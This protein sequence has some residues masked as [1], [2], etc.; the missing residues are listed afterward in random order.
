MRRIVIVAGEASGD[1]HGAR[2]ARELQ[3]LEPNLEIVGVGGY[4]MKQAGVELLYDSSKWGVVG[5]V[6]A[7]KLIPRLWI[8][9]KRLERYLL[10]TKPD[11]LVLIDFGAFNVRLAKRLKGSGIPVLY[12]FPP[13]A[14]SK[15]LGKARNVMKYVDKVCAT[16]PRS[17]ET[18]TAVGADVMFVGHPVLDSLD[19]ICTRQDARKRFGIGDSELTI[20]LLP[21]SRRQEIQQLLPIMLEACGLVGKRLGQSNQPDRGTITHIL[22]IAF[23]HLGRLIKGTVAKS[24]LCVKLI[25]GDAYSVMRASDVV[26]VG[27]GTAT[28]EAA[29]LG[30][31]LV[32]VARLSPI[33]YRFIMRTEED[34][35]P[36]FVSL[37][38]DILSKRVVPE[39]LQDDVT[40]ENI[41]EEVYSLLTDEKRRQDML[42]AFEEL[43]EC[44]GTPPVSK[45]CALA[46]LELCNRE[47]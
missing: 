25:E 12:Y 24:G 2:L 14:W 9:M 20:G 15:D 21:G 27:A 5:I 46:V 36:E 39:F 17:F 40:P 13:A 26:I 16:F 29:V 8:M 43:R 41:A 38:N 33:D 4:R 19:S 34:N 45:K 35:I 23:P 3:M 6:G 47:H 37:P 42:Q 10:E 44:L 31:P 11:S 32:C 30:I 28:L 22:P 7:I 18:Y 1:A